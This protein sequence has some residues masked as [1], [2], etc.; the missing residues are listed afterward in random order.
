MS[1]FMISICWSLILAIFSFMG[2][3]LKELVEGR[4]ISDVLNKSIIKSIQVDKD[5]IIDC[6][7]IYKQPSLNHHS[8][9]NHTIQVKP[10]MSPT[11]MKLDNF[12]TLQI[13][14]TWHKYGKCPQG[15]IPIRRNMKDS[16]SILSHKYRRPK[17]S[18]Y[19]M[20]STVH[21]NGDRSGHEYAVIRV[22][23]N[24]LGAQEKINLW[25]PVVETPLEISVSQ[26]WVRAGEN[27]DLNTIEVGWEPDDYKTGCYNLNC[28]IFVHTS[29][30]I[31]IGC[32][33]TELSAF[34]GDQ[35]DA[36]FSIHKI[37]IKSIYRTK[38]VEI[39]G[40]QVQGIPVGYYPSSLF[41][42]LSKTATEIDFSGEIFN[43]RWKNRHTTTQMGSGHFPSE[44]GL[45]ISSYFNYVQVVDENNEARDPKNVMPV[46][47]NP[48]CYDLKIDEKHKNGYGFYY[49]GPGN[50][51]NDNCQ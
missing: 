14:Q 20:P 4:M 17:F 48:N 2:L 42:Q 13:T 51:D 11:N 37:D 36:T 26:I 33:F 1:K 5:E 6:Y 40:V 43:Q 41:T 10:S 44:G 23:G 28:E 46:V 39:G 34:K 16:R 31:A 15:T 7:D 3:V 18:H 38:I 49:G 9:H 45:G 29:S 8:L 27:D 30:Y 50:N 24:F 32:N 47:S 12:G 19:K 21:S 22:F 35:K 25:N